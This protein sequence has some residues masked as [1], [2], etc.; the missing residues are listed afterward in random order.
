MKK[1]MKKVIVWTSLLA[2]LTVGFAAAQITWTKVNEDFFGDPGNTGISSMAVYE[3]R[4]YAGTYNSE[5]GTEIWRYNRRSWTQVNEDGFKEDPAAA[6]SNWCSLSMAVY[7]G[8]L[9][10]GTGNHNGTELWRYDRTEWVYVETGIEEENKEISSMA[11]YDGCLY[12]GTGISE[13][14][15]I[16]RYDGTEWVQVNEDG[17]GDVNNSASSS[18]AVY[19]GCLYVGTFNYNGAEIWRYNAGVWTPVVSLGFGYTDNRG[20]SSMAVYKG[21]L[22]V[23]TYSERGAE[24]WKY[25]GEYWEWEIKEGIGNGCNEV[26]SSMAVYDGCLYV[27]TWNSMTG[28]E[29]LRYD[30]TM[31]VQVNEDGF[32]EDVLSCSSMVVLDYY[33]RFGFAYRELYVGTTIEATVWVM[34]SPRRFWDPDGGRWF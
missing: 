30:G 32:G 19:N 6:K 27:G 25:N 21:C 9:Y 24:I 18:M 33:E 11:V 13:G 3:G 15:E 34:G 29:I 10:V 22:Y 12:V 7:N 20:I 28:T 5:T 17:F 23:G 26:S 8:C 31:W 1:V 4:L 2:V 16:W 14:T